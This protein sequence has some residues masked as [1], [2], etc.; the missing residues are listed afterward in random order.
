M[1]SNEC[2]RCISY[3]LWYGKSNYNTSRW[4]VFVMTSAHRSS[5]K[6]LF[7][8]PTTDSSRA[9]RKNPSE[10]KQKSIGCY[11]RFTRVSIRHTDGCTGGIGC[12]CKLLIIVIMYYCYRYSRYNAHNV[13]CPRIHGVGN[14]GSC[15]GPAT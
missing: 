8:T 15:P 7:V 9:I 5:E 1:Q 13:V 10:A 3:V 14:R 11:V 12:R 2:M 6:V 4:Y